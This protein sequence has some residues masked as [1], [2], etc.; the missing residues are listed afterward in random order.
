MII[1]TILILDNFENTSPPV[2]C[3]TKTTAN[4]P[5][6]GN[7]KWSRKLYLKQPFPDNHVDKE[8]FLI[9]L[10]RN[11]NVPVYTFAGIG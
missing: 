9:Q 10:Q 4:M 7:I 5:T 11:V 6:M 3:N 2:F 8:T 1:I